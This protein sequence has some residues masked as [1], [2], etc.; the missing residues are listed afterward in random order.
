MTQAAVACV[1]GL[2][3]AIP[4]T[5]PNLLSSFFL[6][7]TGGQVSTRDSSQVVSVQ[8]SLHVAYMVFVAFLENV[9]YYSDCQYNDGYG[10][11]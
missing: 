9:V 5:P 3:R 1:V 7:G 4:W 2:G 10:D 8:F 6:D 11:Q